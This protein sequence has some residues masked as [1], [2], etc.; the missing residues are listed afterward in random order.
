MTK[1]LVGYCSTCLKETKHEVIN[2]RDSVWWKIFENIFTFGFIAALGYDY[3][4]ECTRCRTINV[5]HK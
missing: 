2:C 5:I 1:Y 3:N 4:C